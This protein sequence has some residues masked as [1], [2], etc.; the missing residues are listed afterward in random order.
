[1]NKTILKCVLCGCLWVLAVCTCRAADN[2]DLAQLRENFKKVLLYGDTKTDTLLADLIQIKPEPIVSDQAVVE[3]QQRY[4]ADPKTVA[5]YVASL[6]ADGSWADINY[7]DTK[8]SGWDA[9]RHAARVLE[10]S[11]L[12]VAPGTAYYHSEYIWDGIVRALRYW[13]TTKPVCKNWWYNKI[14]MP[15]AFGEAFMLIGDRLEAAD[16]AAAIELMKASQLGMTG[17][18][19]IWLAGN[20]LMRAIL[21]DNT[22]LSEEAHQAIVSEI[23]LGRLE[24]I[25]DDWSFHQHGPQ[26]QFGNYGMS[27][28]NSMAF[29]GK[30]FRGTGYQFGERETAILSSFITEGF[31]WLIWNRQMDINGLGRQ[32]F[33]NGPIHKGYAVAFAAADLGL[34]VSFPKHANPLV[35]HKH[36]QCSDYTVHRAPHWMASV[37]MSSNRVIGTEL[38]NEDNLKGYY[39]GD[40][41]TYYYKQGDEYLNVYPFWDWRKIPGVTAYEDNAPMPNVNRTKSG[42]QTDLVGGLAAA[43]CGM[44]S[45]ELKRDGLKA[46]KSWMMTD[47]F[48]ACLG[49]GIASDSLL[50]VT[51]SV[52]QCLKRE[53]LQVLTRKGWTTIDGEQRLGGK[54]LRFYHNGTGYIVLGGDTCVAQAEMR[55]GRWHDF[56]GTYDPATVKGEVVSLHLR[57]GVCPDGGRYFYIVLPEATK[58]DVKQFNV[59]KKVQIVRNDASAQIL[60]LPQSHDY[61]ATVYVPGEIS[62]GR[63]KISIAKPGVYRLGIENGTL[64][65]RQQA[66][67]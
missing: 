36:F 9:K 26:M 10:L 40:G 63:K 17:Q 31:C 7:R 64:S 32:L 35:G 30:L 15:K 19:K 33:H 29:F 61:W 45:M 18:N 51:T 20:V 47:E 59:A 24:G 49:A 42:N 3:L 14:A 57:H 8:R 13:F 55:E 2:G 52:D 62:V 67:F 34:S 6:S 1:M 46:Y 48:V 27:F 65:I 5:G 54:D 12:Y 44:T 28:I 25:K 21:E 11:K 43:H 58:D 23:T 41:A 39:M 22:A 38:V 37:R 60:C 66:A 50:P 4:P 56:M 53:D 16:K